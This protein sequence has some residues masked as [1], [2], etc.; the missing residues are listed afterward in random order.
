MS[1]FFWGLRFRATRCAVNDRLELA[2][3]AQPVETL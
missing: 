1:G 3:T 2:E